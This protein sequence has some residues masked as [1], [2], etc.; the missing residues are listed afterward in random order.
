M[1]G[2]ATTAVS[3]QRIAEL[4]ALMAKP[5]AAVAPTEKEDRVDEI[6][7]ANK[8]Q[9][10]ALDKLVPAPEEWNFFGRPNEEQYA[11]IFQ[12]I[13][14]YGLWHPCT[15]WE[16]EDGTYMILGG[17]TRHLVY[18]ELYA[19]TQD[20]KYLSIPCKIYTK[21]QINEYTARRIII[22]TNIAQRAQESPK[23]RVRCYTEMAKLEKLDSFYGSGIDVNAAVAKLFGVSRTSVIL[24]R[25]LGN[26]IEPLTIALDNK[27]YQF[28]VAAMIADLPPELQQYI[29]DKQYHLT[30]NTGVKKKLM[31]ATTPADIDK[32]INGI[33]AK[34]ETHSYKVSTKVTMPENYTFLPVAVGNDE[35]EDFKNFLSQSLDLA[36]NI[37]A[38]TKKLIL[39]MLK[40]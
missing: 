23:I 38:K 11:L 3:P 30:L 12:S 16:Q 19:V 26:L 15:V 5:T 9:T 31:M 36:D 40:N 29:Y 22:L 33:L 34:N 20:E 39:E 2:D 25:K 7:P 6:L 24:W 13:Y 10:I 27:E 37:S 35:V 1:A 8:E 28:K 14:T 32:I 17:H 18:S 4:Q 21:D